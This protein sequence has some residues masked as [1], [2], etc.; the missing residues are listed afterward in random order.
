MASKT[1]SLAVQLVRVLYNETEGLPRQWRTIPRLDRAASDAVELAS[2]RGWIQVEGG[3][4][5]ALTDVGR[6]LAE[7]LAQPRH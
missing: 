3:N 7:D 1:E 2:A 5:V 6:Q 4:S